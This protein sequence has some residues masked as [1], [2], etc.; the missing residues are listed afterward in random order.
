MRPGSR[1]SARERGTIA[2]T[3]ETLPLSEHVDLFAC[4][5]ALTPRER[6]LLHLLTNGA[7]NAT[8]ATSMSISLFTV[9]D[10]LK[11]I[12]AKSGA[13]TRTELIAQAT[14]GRRAIPVDP[15]QSADVRGSV[16]SEL[17][18]IDRAKVA[19]P[20]TAEPI[21]AEPMTTSHGPERSAEIQPGHGIRLSS[22]SIS[23]SSRSGRCGSR[24]VAPVRTKPQRV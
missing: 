8:I 20:I 17:T 22:S 6:Q 16:R 9:Q 13:R 10:H 7:D 15:R 2:I 14:A 12:Y 4:V 3:I 18:M 19:E 21:A 5:T 1:G 24:M 11:S 23:C